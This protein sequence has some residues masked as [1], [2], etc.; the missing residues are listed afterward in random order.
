MSASWFRM[1]AVILVSFFFPIPKAD[2]S[3]LNAEEAKLTLETGMTVHV[4][5]RAVMSNAIHH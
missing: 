5:K 1:L 2:F 4:N 3:L